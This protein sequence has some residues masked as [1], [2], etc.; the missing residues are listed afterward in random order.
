MTQKRSFM[1]YVV[2]ILV[3]V[4][5]I[6]HQD[7]WNWDNRTLIFGFMPIGLL[8]H[9]L[10]SVSCA[11]L[12]ALAIKFAWPDHIEAWADEFEAP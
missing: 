12:W 1:F 6:V 7:F 10:F 9:A 3:V 8:Y 2:W 11:T 5:A 4:L